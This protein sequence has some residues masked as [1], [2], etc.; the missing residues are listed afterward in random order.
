MD[1]P[2]QACSFRQSLV[3]TRV[4]SLRNL[5]KSKP[6]SDPDRK[7]GGHHGQHDK[8]PRLVPGRGDDEV[9]RRALFVPDAVIVRGDHVEAVRARPQVGVKR[10]TP[11]SRFLPRVFPAFQPVSKPYFLR[12]DEAESRVID[13]EVSSQGR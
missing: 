9:E 8:R 7:D 6:E 13:L 11:A 4:E 1:V 5:T 10:L 3:E 2:C 12:R